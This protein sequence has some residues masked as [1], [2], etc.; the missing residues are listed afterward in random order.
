MSAGLSTVLDAYADLGPFSIWTYRGGFLL[1]TLSATLAL[2]RKKFGPT[3][4]LAT[5]ASPIPVEKHEGVWVLFP[6]RMF[7]TVSLGTVTGDTQIEWVFS[8]QAYKLNE[9]YLQ[10]IGIPIAF[11]ETLLSLTLGQLALIRRVDSSPNLVTQNQCEAI[12]RAGKVSDPSMAFVRVVGLGLLTESPVG[13]YGLTDYGLEIVRASRSLLLHDP[14]VLLAYRMVTIG[15]DAIIRV[16]GRAPV[17]NI[18]PAG[19]WRGTFLIG[20]DS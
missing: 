4:T 18:G 20:R 6:Y 10:V 13:R 12:F 5:Q 15:I 14:S 2:M 1:L 16:D 19:N 3:G 7:E 9:P 8:W 17:P 11:L